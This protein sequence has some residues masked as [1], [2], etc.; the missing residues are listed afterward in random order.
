MN[1]TVA[2]DF[3]SKTN[4]TVDPLVEPPLP[5][6]AIVLTGIG[7]CVLAVVLW[8]WL[9]SCVNRPHSRDN[10]HLT[11]HPYPWYCCIPPTKPVGKFFCNPGYLF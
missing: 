5:G 10:R 3:E 9:V 2:L 11:D 6:W 1:V 4:G 8:L 7:L